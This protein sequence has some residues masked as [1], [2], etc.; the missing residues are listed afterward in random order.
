MKTKRLFFVWVCIAIIIV[1]C[2]V[3]WRFNMKMN[4]GESNVD[5]TSSVVEESSDF[6]QDSNKIVSIS[7]INENM[8]GQVVSIQGTVVNIK[9]HEKGHLFLT[10]EDSTGSISVPIFANTNINKDIIKEDNIYEI[11]GKV[12]VYNG[13]LEII[14]QSEE[15]ISMIRTSN[16]DVAITEENI[17]E[18]V[19]IKC[20]IL[21]KYNHPEGHI[22]L[23]V[24]TNN[25]EEI[26]VPIFNTL[27][28]SQ[29]NNLNAG[30]YI[31]VNGVISKYNGE[32]E[33]IPNSKEDIE[34]ISNNDDANDNNQLVS[35]ADITRE[36][37]GKV[38]QVRGVPINLVEKEGHLFFYLEDGQSTIKAVLF[39][40]DGEEIIGRKQKLQHYAN[41]NR[42]VRVLGSVD[43]YNNELEIIIDKVF[44]E[45]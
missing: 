14:P 22:F 3:I 17:G 33:V 43:V 44:N 9:E 39:R 42:K 34:I 24:L 2:G 23:N 26:E 10:V 21:S 27:E 16:N 4:M 36:D 41:S 32:L 11:K 25:D 7:E 5:E 35:L 18:Q 19:S 38:V 15:D 12:D 13:Y 1:I 45:D 29:E 28:Y 31:K 37:R 30:D 8:K 40:A 20:T 6:V